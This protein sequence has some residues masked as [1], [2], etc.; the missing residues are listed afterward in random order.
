MSALLLTAAASAAMTAAMTVPAHAAE[1]IK[2]RLTAIQGGNAM[3]VSGTTANDVFQFDGS[4]GTITVSSSTGPVS[5]VSGCT[6]VGTSKVRCSGVVL[7]Q[8]FGGSGHDKITN[9]TAVPLGVNGGSDND[10]LTGG[11]GRDTLNGG[12]G[13]DVADGR[14]GKDTCSAET[15]F[16]CEEVTS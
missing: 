3:S 7:I 14:G 2:V 1:P 10:T 4:G 13:V 6:Q 16:S 9:N 12:F 5:A 15:V 11:P 8:A